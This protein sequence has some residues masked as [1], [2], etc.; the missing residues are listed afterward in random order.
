LTKPH[1]SSS[2]ICSSRE[3][4][5]MT[6]RSIVHTLFPKILPVLLALG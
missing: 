1:G 6:R 3:Y 4:R 2:D 5:D